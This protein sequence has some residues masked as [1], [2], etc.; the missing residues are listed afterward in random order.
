MD[1]QLSCKRET[2]NKDRY[3]VAVLQDHNTVGH[4]PRKISA[5]CSF[6]SREEA[7]FVASSQG[8]VAILVI[9]LKEV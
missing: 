4:L 2:G 1:E 6:F 7:L 8:N 9:Y 3:A 5:A